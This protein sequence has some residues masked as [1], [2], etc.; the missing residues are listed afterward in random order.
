[1]ADWLESFRQKYGTFKNENFDHRK[2][3]RFFSL[4]TFLVFH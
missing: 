2:A 3:V 1:M 4:N